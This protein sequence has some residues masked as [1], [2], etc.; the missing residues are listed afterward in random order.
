MTSA[1]KNSSACTEVRLRAHQTG[2]GVR[3]R[4]ERLVASPICRKGLWR[5]DGPL[6]TAEAARPLVDE[7]A[8]V[9]C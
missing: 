6:L 7:G 4:V 3:Y 8:F 1:F 2:A 9:V 5:P